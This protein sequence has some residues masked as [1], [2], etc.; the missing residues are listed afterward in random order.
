MKIRRLFSAAVAATFCFASGTA[1]AGYYTCGTTN[2]ASNPRTCPDGSIPVY[3]SGTL[4]SSTPTL[5][6]ITLGNTQLKIGDSTSINATPSTATLGSC[7]SSNAGVAS[8]NGSTVTA[9]ATGSVTITCGSA[10]ASLTVSAPS[11]TSTL[12]GI[13]LGSSSLA[14]G[15][16]TSITPT[17]S[18]ATLGTCSSSNS[19]VASV[20]GSTVTALA[21]G[22][23][24]ITCGSAT[25]NLTVSAPA[26][27]GGPLSFSASPVDFG[28]VPVAE[29]GNGPQSINITV[30]A[31]DYVAFSA[32]PV[33]SGDTSFSIDH[34]SCT[35]GYS[36]LPNGRCNVTVNF[37]PVSTGLK[38]AVLTL[39][40]ESIDAARTPRTYT[41]NL[42][43]TGVDYETN[44]ALCAGK[45]RI[46]GSESDG[47]ITAKTLSIG[48]AP[49]HC[50]ILKTGSVYVWA[51]IPGAGIFMY[52]STGNWSPLKG[53]SVPAAFSGP[54]PAVKS[55]LPISGLNLS[56]LLGTT[57]YAGYGTGSDPLVAMLSNGTFAKT[58]T[59]ADKPVDSNAVGNWAIYI[60][61]TAYIDAFGW[62]T[63]SPQAPAGNL[64]I[65]SDGSWT[66]VKSSGTYKGNLHEYRLSKGT[67]SADKWG[68]V[69]DDNSSYY[70]F[71]TSNGMSLYDAG[72]NLY[73][74][75]AGKK[76]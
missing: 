37:S 14:I 32:N 66:W 67:V 18:T 51:Q 64:T 50:D 19:S 6:A 21:S 29:F 28:K 3:N 59:V 34:A 9:L 54:L 69:Y 4:P 36:L 58:H 74:F 30:T 8:I 45:E 42:S 1:L 55:L 33:I 22:S 52:D 73:A 62:W 75:S 70:V 27:T 23:A 72:T 68:T 57:F 47:V 20:S 65:N 44:Q 60:A 13:T 35:A 11:T 26:S 49:A 53:G 10:T 39:K 38:S 41:I 76:R 31:S 17:P 5:T 46:S 25:A 7:S 43:G 71:L 16:T 2:Y 24:T 12:T 15:A 40:T 61:G 56:P 63:Y 48:V